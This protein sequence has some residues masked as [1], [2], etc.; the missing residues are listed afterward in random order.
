[1]GSDWLVW[2][3]DDRLWWRANRCGYTRSVEDA[4]RY[5]LAEAQ[6]IATVHHEDC[7]DD[8]PNPFPSIAI[9]PAR[10]WWNGCCAGSPRRSRSMASR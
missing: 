6:R 4:G 10:S 1:M 9:H 5:T 2:S 3:N 8:Q 7:T